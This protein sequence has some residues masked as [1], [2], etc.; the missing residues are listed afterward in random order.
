MQTTPLSGYED[1]TRTTQDGSD[2][3]S[4]PQFMMDWSQMQLSIGYDGMPR[5][6]M[7]LGPEIN[8]DPSAM[9]IGAPGEPM[10]G[11]MPDFA[12]NMASLQTPMETP[13]F[14]RH[15]SDLD[16]GTSTP[17]FQPLSR[18]MSHASIHSVRSV[19][20][21]V[22]DIGGEL[23][24]IV[25]AQ[26]GWSV[27]R[28][29]P[30]ITSSSCPRTARPNLERLEHSLRNHETWSKWSPTWDESEF[31]SGE[32]LAV[33]PLHESSRDKLLAITQTFLH[34][35]LDIHQDNGTS[36]A[37]GSASPSRSS[38][39]NV[40]LLPP[41]R[42]LE[43]F[44]RSYANSFERYYS[45]TS[46]GM[47]D[48]NELLH[49]Y[50]EKAS[51]LLILMM[52]AQGAMAIPSMDGRWLAGG[53]TEACRISLF[54]LIEKNIIMS[55]DPI[56][57]HSALLFTALAAWSGDK[58]Q[59]DIAMGQRGMYFAM[60]RH[61]GVLEPRQQPPTPPMDG[62]NSDALWNDWIQHESRSR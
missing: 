49:C 18:H 4:S 2:P 40:V 11:M 31:A 53:L 54:D 44:L 9:P 36:L 26:D 20:T 37:P 8:L 51:S 27:F 30:T 19:H 3:G 24:A 5:P 33:M 15:F 42:V 34:K 50:N 52:I 62:S 59:M 7:M 46:R 60:L 17:V 22:G 29:T 35:A 32:Q 41:T 39:S 25:A 43:Y 45:L 55:G 13:K 61:S 23:S 57:L 48:A 47:L 14:E 12:N 56:V 28:C 10:V 58:W 1:F 38:S 16:L 21:P 6:D